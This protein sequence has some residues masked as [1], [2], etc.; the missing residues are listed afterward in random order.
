MVEPVDRSDLDSKMTA[1]AIVA[2]SKRRRKR[3]DLRFGRFVKLAG[4]GATN[5][6]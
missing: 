3:G 5:D 6:D 1:A 4:V 2:A